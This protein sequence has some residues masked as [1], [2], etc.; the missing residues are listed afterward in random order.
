MGEI[1]RETDRETDRQRERTN[2]MWKRREKREALLDIDAQLIVNLV[3]QEERAEP[4]R[5]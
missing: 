1:E 4:Q 2:G 5:G 3:K